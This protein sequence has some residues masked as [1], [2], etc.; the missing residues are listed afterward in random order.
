MSV[1]PPRRF[2]A[3]HVSLNPNPFRQILAKLSLDDAKSILSNP[4][5]DTKYKQRVLKH[6]DKLLSAQRSVQQQYLWYN[7][8]RPNYKALILTEILAIGLMS[9]TLLSYKNN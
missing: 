5:N 1:A 8:Y 3:H 7:N 9:I 6:L 2:P 4:L